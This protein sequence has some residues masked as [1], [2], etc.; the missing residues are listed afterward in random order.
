K[1]SGGTGGITFSQSTG[2]PRLRLSSS[3]KV[4]VGST[5]ARGNYTATGKVTDSYGDSGTWTYTLAVSASAITQAAPKSNGSVVT[6]PTSSKFTA[7][8]AVTGN[9]GAVKYGLTNGHSTPTGLVISS[10]GAVS[11][12]GALAVGTYTAA[13]TDSDSLGDSGPWS[14]SLTITA[15]KIT[16][17]APIEGTTTTAAAFASKLKVARFY[18]TVT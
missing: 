16:Q 10:S 14:Y 17:S 18:G 7:H 4:T 15:T 12:T 6:P 11:T 13:G 2:A 3:G 5:L 8:L 1:T 9:N